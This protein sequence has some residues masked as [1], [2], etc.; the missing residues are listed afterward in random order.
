M[1][2][3]LRP[4][5]DAGA[6]GEPQPPAFRLFSRYFEPLTPPDTLHPLG[7]DPPTL[8]AQQRGD[9]AIAIAAIGAGQSD[10]RG[11]Q[12]RFVIP[13][14]A[15]FALGRAGLTNSAAGAPFRNPEPLL[16]MDHALAS[17]FGA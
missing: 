16:Q 2:G 11:A 1:A 3:V 9:A 17:A 7:I 10:D 14:Q 15:R 12:R 8:G 13:Y 4:Q 6:V 5:P